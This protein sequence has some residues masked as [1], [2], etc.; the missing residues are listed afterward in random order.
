MAKGF[1]QQ[2]LADRAQ[3][4]RAQ[5]SAIEANRHSP[6]VDA[7]LRLA[8][9]LDATVEAI[10]AVSPEP[11]HVGLVAGTGPVVVSRVGDRRVHA[12]LA[13]LVA[14]DGWGLADGV[15]GNGVVGNGVVGNGTLGEGLDMLP[16]ADEHGLLVA[17]C[18]PLL[19]L[20]AAIIAMRRGPRIVAVH[21]STGSAIE[22]LRAGL[23]HGVVVH[24]PARSFPRPPVEVLRWQLGTWQVGIAAM[25]RTRVRSLEELA[26][27]RLRTAQRE[28]GAGS[29]RALERA[30]ARIGASPSLPGPSVSG[31]LDAARSVTLGVPAGVT[32]E[33]AARAFGLE[34]LPL[35]AHRSE[36]WIDARWTD[37]PGAVALVESLTS[38]ALVSRAVLLPGY[39]T[40]AMGVAA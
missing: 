23:A 22:A 19:G 26:S 3:V 38:R 15:V 4:T 14:P 29:Q 36:L 5:V 39:D 24:G 33:A 16:E 18:D 40:Q 21:Q 20:A 27:R 6:S 8:R 13:H 32:M 31:H 2:E 1:T 17:G 37:H 7:A 35:E 9:A 34:F 12:P 25:G 11:I 28:P 10:F 30:L